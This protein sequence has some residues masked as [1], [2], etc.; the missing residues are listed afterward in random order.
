MRCA[1]CVEK[2]K[3]L[4][5]VHTLLLLELLLSPVVVVAVADLNFVDDQNQQRTETT[6]NSSLIKAKL[7]SHKK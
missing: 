5:Y 4:M 2:V 7:A 1:I 6:N 3:L